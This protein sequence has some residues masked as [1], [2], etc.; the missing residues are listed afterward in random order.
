MPRK[1][2]NVKNRKK[3]CQMRLTGFAAKAA[4]FFR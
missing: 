3:R 1:P 4:A 2:E